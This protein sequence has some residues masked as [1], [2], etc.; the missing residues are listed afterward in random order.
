MDRAPSLLRIVQVDYLASVG[1]IMP[2]VLWGLALVT[3][4]FD[5][6]AASVFRLLAAMDSVVGLGM[7]AWRVWTIRRVVA[8]GAGVPG[9]I[10]SIGFFR[11]RGRVEYVYTFQGRQY[12]GGQAIQS[13]AVTRS[14]A[15]GQ[16][17]TVMVDPARPERAFVRELYA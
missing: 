17:V 8:G 4:F 2:V 7:V 15:Q 12:Q 1:V 6:G 3:Q 10:G 13:T 5:P 14:L 11:G 16:A 9:V